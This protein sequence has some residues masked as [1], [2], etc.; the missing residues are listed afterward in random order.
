MF[1]FF[2]VAPC[3][4]IHCCN[5]MR[6]KVPRISL[7]PLGACF[8]PNQLYTATRSKNKLLPYMLF[9][10]QEFRY[11]VSC[12]CPNKSSSHLVLNE[13]LFPSIVLF[14]GFFHQWGLSSLAN[15]AVQYKAIQRNGWALIL[16]PKSTNMTRPL[17]SGWVRFMS[18]LST[19]INNPDLYES[20]LSICSI[21]M[22]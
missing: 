19:D 3:K 5:F 18:F 1:H 7:R 12:T 4:A 20:L 22:E 10:I 8:I 9:L 16:L 17:D 13:I 14:L 11:C 2:F 6:Q 21:L 15:P